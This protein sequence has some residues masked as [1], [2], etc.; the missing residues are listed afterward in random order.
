MDGIDIHTHG[1]RSA[2]LDLGLNRKHR[3]RRSYSISGIELLQHFDLLVDTRHGKII[4]HQMFLTMT[5]SCA[6]VNQSTPQHAKP[7]AQQPYN[8]LLCNYRGILRHAG[9]LTAVNT[10]VT[11][12]I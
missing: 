10:K 4:D 5:G 6:V 3:R 7:P 2:T 9:P 1:H 11:H 12:Y 8:G